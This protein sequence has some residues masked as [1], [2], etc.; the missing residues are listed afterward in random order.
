MR[1]RSMYGSIGTLYGPGPAGP[2]MGYHG[3]GCK[4]IPDGLY[5]PATPSETTPSAPGVDR[6][7]RSGLEPRPFG[8][9]A[10]DT[11]RWLGGRD[12]ELSLCV[13]SGQR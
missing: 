4:D 12:S 5:L 10:P 11:D 9:A 13:E 1:H 2:I 8:G 7:R 6:R 3:Q